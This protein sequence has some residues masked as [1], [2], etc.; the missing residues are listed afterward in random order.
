M[1]FTLHQLQ[2]F[3][4]VV[5]TSSITRSSEELFM[6]QPA[7]SIQL[8]KFQEQFDVP[9][10]E[11]IG[12]QLHITEFGNEIALLAERALGELEAIHYKTQDYK[13]LLTGRL[14]IASASTGKYVIPYFLTEFLDRHNGIDLVLDVTNKAKVVEHL[15]SNTIDF[16][17]VSV[18][19]NK[20]ELEEELLIENK[21]YLL[22][23][24]GDLSDNRPLIYREPGS[25]TRQVME[26]YFIKDD[27]NQRRKLELTTNEAVREA[28]LAGLGY[29]I[30]PLIG[31]KN[32]LLRGDL[33][34][35]PSKG[36]PIKTQWRLI[37]LKNKSL[38]PVAK[39]YISF[40]KNE[41][42]RILRTYFQWYRDF[43]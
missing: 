34:I 26:E 11:V 31:I 9:L 27:K 38:S 10:T 6:T 3:L 4:K 8:K 13:G 29:S 19:P 40:V 1:N 36:L 43:K 37:W 22:G 39:E 7:V 15:V 17:L 42:E 28:V 24:T 12:R 14:K 30:L 33:Q 23:N 5:E 32:P 35:I 2:V 18:L 16:A 25:A 41:K 21:F 20:L